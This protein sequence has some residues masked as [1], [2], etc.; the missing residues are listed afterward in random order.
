MDA[1][2]VR[3]FGKLTQDSGLRSLIWRNDF[4]RRLL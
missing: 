1:A 3:A 4:V 2:V